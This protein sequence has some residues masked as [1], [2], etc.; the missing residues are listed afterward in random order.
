MTSIFRI[1]LVFALALGLVAC[2][3]EDDNGDDDVTVDSAD[4]CEQLVDATIPVMQEILD[5]VSEMSMEDIMSEE[6]PEE[7]ADFET[8]ME[9][10]GE[11]AEDMNCDDDEMGTLL[12]A[13]VGDLTAEGP[14]GELLLEVIQSGEFD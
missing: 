14:V 6:E 10:I 11:R 2:G 13:R 9:E 7:L 8:R 3:S 5:A 12:E 4:T 1:A